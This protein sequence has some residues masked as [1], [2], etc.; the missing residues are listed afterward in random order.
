MA[1]GITVG[2]KS[3]LSSKFK[4]VK[5]LMTLINQKLHKQQFARTMKNTLY[6]E[7][8]IQNLNLDTIE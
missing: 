6:T 8:T 3:K 5:K 1:S 2:I 4:T 7:F